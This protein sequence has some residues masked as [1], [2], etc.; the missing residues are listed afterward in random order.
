VPG[1]KPPEVPITDAERRALLA[2]VRARKT[3]QRTALRARIVLALAEGENAP[4]VA[5]R[6][7]TTRTT[8]RL[9]RSC[10]LGRAG[11]SVDERL[12]DGERTGAPR[13]I[14]AEQWCKILAL[15]CEPPEH[16]GRPITHWTPRELA[17]EAVKQGIVETIS[18]RH[19]GRFLKSDR[20]QTAPESVL[21]QP[22][23]RAR[24]R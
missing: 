4:T 14:T 16:S 20:C 24:R 8:V 13:T 2:L 12:A 3:E 6:L 17:D 22:K 10:W 15:A 21:A 7:S 23:A 18:T 11:R 19:V 5:R 9:W 1:P